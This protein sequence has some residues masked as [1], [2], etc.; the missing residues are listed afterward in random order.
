MMP[1]TFFRVRKICDWGST[2]LPNVISLASFS[3]IE[4]TIFVA[5]HFSSK[6]ISN[7]PKLKKTLESY[8]QKMNKIKV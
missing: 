7:T 1:K 6:F 5:H 3:L 2:F 8:L 4:T